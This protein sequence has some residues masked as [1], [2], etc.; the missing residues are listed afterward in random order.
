MGLTVLG[1][2]V[3]AA[4]AK[5][6][7]G[8]AL[9]LSGGGGGG[10]EKKMA[11]KHKGLPLYLDY[12]ATCP[13]YPEVV[14]AMLPYLYV[15]WGNPSSAHGYGLAPRLAVAEARRRVA[16][17]INAEHD[18]EIVFC[19]CGSE[20]DNW[21]ILG[22]LEKSQKKRVVV[23]S[24]E[25][26]AILACVAALEEKGL[27]EGKIVGC[28]KYGF[29]KPEAVA[30][31]IGDKTAVVSVMLA[32]NEVGSVQDVAAIVKAVKAKDPEVIV[33]SDAAQAVGKIPVDVQKLNVDLLTLVGHKFGAPKGVAVLY[34]KRGVVL[35]NMLYGGGQ[36]AGRR[37]GTEAVPNIVALGEAAQIWIDSGEDVI[38][39]CIKMRDRL[40]AR[41]RKRL[42]SAAVAGKK[43]KIKINGPLGGALFAKDDFSKILPN[44]LSFAVENVPA[45]TIL[46]DIGDRVAASAS[47]AC[48]SGAAGK[49]SEVLL[50]LG[51]SEPFARGTFRL[52]VGRHTTPSGVDEAADIL[53]RAILK[54]LQKQRLLLDKR[55]TTTKF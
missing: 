51:V 55:T 49:I 8:R 1:T 14:A 26:P 40:E 17:L 30:E 36:E 2:L 4:A 38:T 34:V 52:S 27:A 37:A 50:A 6:V 44:V 47:A 45:S 54:E 35:P 33:H 20:A 13:V 21:A 9:P 32:N 15:H 41:L 46:Q 22:C 19:S 31:A 42:L 12:A 28:D 48:H 7:V 24:I 53:A 5:A 3:T 16:R 25:H 10:S 23:S 39:S 11:K 43:I 29:V 18:D